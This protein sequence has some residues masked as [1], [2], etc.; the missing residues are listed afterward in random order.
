MTESVEQ[1]KLEL[2]RQRKRAYQ[3]AL[4]SP[5]GMEVLTD[6][7]RFCRA[8]KTTYHPDPDKRLVLLGRQEV[9]LRIQNY[10]QLNHAQLYAL[11]EGKPFQLTIEEDKSDVA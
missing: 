1:R 11:A 8:A 5:A 9:F 3:L 10:L 7:A 4:T 2:L 6:L